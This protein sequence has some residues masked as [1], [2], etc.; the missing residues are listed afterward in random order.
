M[1]NPDIGFSL[2]EQCGP[3]TTDLCFYTMFGILIEEPADRGLLN[4]SEND[5]EFFDSRGLLKIPI[6]SIRQGI[7]PDDTNI[8][9]FE[10]IFV[11]TEQT[12]MLLLMK[13]AM[14]VLRKSAFYLLFEHHYS[15]IIEIIVDH[16][17]VP[18]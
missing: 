4:S 17:I 14:D 3:E 11:E 12:M 9:N 5:D 16:D 7:I 8:S 2:Y 13:V 18:Q 15:K 10:D 6:N 1:H